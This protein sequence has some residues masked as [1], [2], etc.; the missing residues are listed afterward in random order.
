MDAVQQS[1]VDLTRFGKVVK[2]VGFKPFISALNALEQC[3]AISEGKSFL[4]HS[5]HRIVVY[6]SN[7]SSITAISIIHG[8]TVVYCSFMCVV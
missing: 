6:Y 5:V 2:L 4:S 1:V 8:N 7:L 3:N